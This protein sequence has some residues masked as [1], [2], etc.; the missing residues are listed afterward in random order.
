MS[1]QRIIN[2]T[3]QANK[4]FSIVDDFVLS[5]WLIQNKLTKREIQRKRVKKNVKKYIFLY[6][7][8]ITY[9]KNPEN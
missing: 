7:I 1:E 6:N 8:N 2:I 5:I 4:L 3:K 9:N